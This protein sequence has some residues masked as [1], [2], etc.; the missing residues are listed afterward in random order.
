LVRKHDK[1]RVLGTRH[2]FNGISDSGDGDLISLKHMDRVLEFD[3]ND[4]QQPTVT[5]EA[6]IT[7]GQLC[8]ILDREGYAL[9]NLASLPHI[10][11]A[12][13]CATATHG[14]GVKNKN[15]AAAVEAMQIVKY[16]E[17]SDSY[18]ET[19]VSREAVGDEFEG[20]VVALGGLGVVT[21]ITLKLER[22][23]EVRQEVY[24]YLPQDRL[25]HHFDEIMGSAYSV[26]LF[27]NWQGSKY[28]QVWVKHRVGEQESIEKRPDSFGAMPATTHMHPI[29]HL[30]AEN[31]TPSSGAEL[32]TEYFVPRTNALGALD[33]IFEMREK[34]SPLLQISEV[35]TIAGDDFWMS[36]CYGKEPSV[37]IHFTWERNSP[38][39]ERLLE[40]DLEPKLKQFDARP[41]WGK[42][43]SM[44]GERLAELYKDGGRFTRFQELLKSCDKE[45]KFRNSYLNEY[46]PPI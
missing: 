36:P 42:L 10:S 17:E 3:L 43:F 27:T 7:Y 5:V 16:N 28:D 23:F 37:G 31:C 30:S 14:S 15:M 34:I 4:R 18:E 40:K 12:G 32:Q 20:M 35:R 13:A 44:Q 1:I 33:A 38:A 8:P 6:G 19:E 2:S 29:A 25:K 45:G 46:V 11:V 9:H 22:R 21:S 41:H 26:S 39:V 24:L